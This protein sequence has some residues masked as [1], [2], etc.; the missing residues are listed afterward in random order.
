M[1]DFAQPL[2]SGTLML[3]PAEL[4][5]RIAE[6]QRTAD[7][8]L[9]LIPSRSG[10]AGSIVKERHIHDL[11]NH[12][13]GVIAVSVYN[14]ANIAIANN[15]DTALTFDS[16]R[17]DTDSIHSTSSNTGRLTATI[18]GKYLITALVRWAANND[19]RRSVWIRE[20]GDTIIALVQADAATG[21]V[22]TVQE[23][24]R[25]YNLKA[26]E[27]VEVLVN[28]NSGGALNVEAVSNFSPEFMMARVGAA[29]G[30]PPATS[31]ADHGGL[32]GLGDDDHTI[33]LLAAG[34]RTG[35]TGAAQDFGSTG[36]KADVIAES[37]GAT[38]V[39][40]DGVKLKDGNVII[41]DAGY[42]GSVS[43]TDAIQIEADGDVV[44]TQDL[45]VTGDVT[46]ANIVTA[47]NVDGV[48]ISAWIDQDVTSGSAPTF[49]QAITDNH[50]VTIDGT[51]NDTEHA[52]FNA[53]GLE[54]LTDAELLAALSGDAGAAFSWN[55]QNLT[56]VGTIGCGE[57][58]VADGSSINL[59][60]AL[61]FTGATTENLIEFPDNLADALSFEEG[62]TAYMTF[63][64]TNGAE[65][66]I[67]EKSLYIKEQAAALVD[68]AAYGQIWVKN[69]APNELWFTDDDGTDVQLGAGG[70]ALATDTLWAAA[71]DLVK[72]TG[73]DAAD[74]LTIGAA[75]S[76]VCTLDGAAITWETAPE[77]QYIKDTGGTTRITTAV[78]NPHLTLTGDTKIT[79]NLAVGGGAVVSTTLIDV[80][81]T[82]TLN[83]SYKM[84]DL[85]TRLITTG[86]NRSLWGVYAVSM[87]LEVADAS[88][89]HHAYGLN[90]QATAA[91]GGGAAS[92][93]TLRG[94]AVSL[95]ASFYTG[96][97]VD[98]TGIY[99]GAPLMIAGAPSMTTYRG[100]FVDGDG[101][102]NNTIVD[103]YS[104]VIENATTP[105]GNIRLLEVGGTV[106]TLPYLRVMGNF[107][108]AA[109]ET[110]IYVSEGAT[111][112][113][114]Q[115]KTK[116]G[117]AIGGGD[118]VC[119][120]V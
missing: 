20:G 24:S 68:V 113:L 91:G 38:G 63:D 25:Q 57:I 78:A 71:G 34:T 33:Y 43:D 50:V 42:I 74:I 64:S 97:I 53:A 109:N 21:G 54:G 56:S 107:T 108:A 14:S 59:Q 12:P 22:F 17:W 8:A 15:T 93:S 7:Q 51:A 77:L 100:V 62:G 83:S 18:A 101:L 61:T 117:A 103:W 29:G 75:H 116:D 1:R 88:T 70:G 98:G 13:G 41:A 90:F 37:T 111:P 6:A 2:G 45:A 32:T 27:Y 118:L 95:A 4:E 112:T 30:A 10:S 48:D 39:T 65:K 86:N 85:G 82:I 81:A 26:G 80:P 92:F 105:T 84:L 40:L 104:M 120:L 49:A 28:Q 31:G 102:N 106:G 5:E 58:T 9:S 47:G 66:V 35:S 67:F 46:A 16:E 99:V 76:I 89:G 19:G 115:L 36:I 3:T 94:I 119:V 23:V 79:G 72:G 69:A 114:R 52:V 96:T 11:G 87:I 55:S 60:E 110:P 44:L 73:D